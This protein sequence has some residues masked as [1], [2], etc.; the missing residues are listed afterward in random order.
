MNNEELERVATEL[1]ERIVI[2]Y[3]NMSG[4]EDTNRGTFR[5]ETFKKT[6]EALTSYANSR[7]QEFVREVEL[8]IEFQKK[9]LPSSYEAGYNH[10]IND[11]I[12]LSK[13]YITTP[14]P[15]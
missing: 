4:R 6:K 7:I 11:I 2:D 13:K 14:N 15:A 8:K 12:D 10:A 1:T 3:A 9:V 5:A